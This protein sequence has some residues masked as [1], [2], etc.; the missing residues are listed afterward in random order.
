MA[1]RFSEKEYKQLLGEDGPSSRKYRNKPV[2]FD[3]HR[4]DSE[5]ERDV[6]AELRLLERAGKIKDLKTQPVFEIVPAVRREGKPIQRAITYRADFSYLEDGE[7]RVV[8]AKGVKTD[9]YKLKK[10]L[11][12][13]LLDIEIIEV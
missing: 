4:F 8:D 5:H 7:L 1:V 2:Y 6:Y 13:A 3:G 11:M 10:K 9:V 12:L